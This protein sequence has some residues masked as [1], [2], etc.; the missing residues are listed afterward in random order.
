[1]SI[2][3]MTV[4]SGPLNADMNSKLVLMKYAENHY[5]IQ[6]HNLTVIMTVIIQQKGLHFCHG[7]Q[8]LRFPRN[9]LFSFHTA[10]LSQAFAEADGNLH[11]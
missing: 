7:L 9:L 6:V 11:T 8:A 3:S 2:S 10:L 4:L 5:R 1:M